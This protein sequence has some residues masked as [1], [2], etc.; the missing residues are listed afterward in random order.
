MVRLFTPYSHPI[1]TRLGRGAS[2]H[3]LVDSHPLFTP[4]WDVV[5]PAHRAAPRWLRTAS[6]H[7]LGCEQVRTGPHAARALL[8]AVTALRAS[9]RARGGELLIRFGRPE[10]EL[11]LLAARCCA[12]EV[13][14][15]EEAG[16]EERR[17]SS[18]VREAMTRAGCRASAELGGCTLFH[19][20]ELPAADE[21]ASRR[22]RRTAY[23]QTER[24]VNR[25]PT[26]GHPSPTRGKSTPRRSAAARRA[27]LGRLRTAAAAAL[28]GRVA[29]R[30]CLA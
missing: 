30:G 15:H 3:T 8:A 21:P 5:R 16:W 4:A 13:A 18:R 27:P 22:S 6:I 19:P 10:A 14:W 12:G 24:S 26:S 2:I 23:S 28:T 1:H 11:P 17:T 20:D 9:L 25:R 29:S 7:T